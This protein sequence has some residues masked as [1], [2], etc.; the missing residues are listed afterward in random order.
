MGEPLAFEIIDNP[1]VRDELDRICA[2]ARKIRTERRMARTAEAG[3]VIESAV[4]RRH[5]NA[6][7]KR[8]LKAA[9]FGKFVQ[10]YARKAQKGVDPNDRSYS[11]E[12][13][14]AAKRMKPE[15]LDHLLRNDDDGD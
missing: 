10:Q 6:D 7:Q 12:I 1:Q 8:A 14:Q 15:S 9:K 2:A 13:E 5:L 11:R 4:P 3:C